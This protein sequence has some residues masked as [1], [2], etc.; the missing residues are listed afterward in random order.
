MVS[1]REKQFLNAQHPHAMAQPQRLHLFPYIRPL[2]ASERREGNRKE[3]SVFTL[4]GCQPSLTSESCSF[5]L[6][7]CP[8]CIR[9]T[10]FTPQDPQICK[11]SSP[12]ACR[13]MGCSKSW[14]HLYI[15]IMFLTQ[16]EQ[17]KLEQHGSWT[18]IV[19]SH[20]R[21][22]AAEP[23]NMLLNCFAMQAQRTLLATKPLLVSSPK[24]PSS[25]CAGNDWTLAL[26]LLTPWGSV[27]VMT[28]LL[29][30]AAQQETLMASPSSCSEK[31]LP[32]L[33]PFPCGAAGWDLLSG[34]LSAA[35]RARG[36]LA[37]AAAAAPPRWGHQPARCQHPFAPMQGVG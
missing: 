31:A 36:A 29:V 27:N 4:L 6:Q 25:P 32:S 14:V 20:I 10:C 17:G 19:S 22:F 18:N 15:V 2:L 21:Y 26:N 12:D 11:A 28:S 24:P 5:T 34:L 9:K 33:P 30:S 3:A 23:G 8:K 7:F 37:A 13:S 35:S 1:L 16:A